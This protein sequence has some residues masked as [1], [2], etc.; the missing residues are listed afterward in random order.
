MMLMINAPRDLSLG[1]RT[2]LVRQDRIKVPLRE[3][4][5]KQEK[6]LI[7]MMVLPQILVPLV[8]LRLEGKIKVLR[9][10][11]IHNQKKFQ[12]VNNV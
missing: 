12:M 5:V 7:W 10:I 6:W 1:R 11:Q 3:I 9:K 4:H 2:D 8:I